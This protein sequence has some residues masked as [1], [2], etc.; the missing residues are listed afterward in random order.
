M[1]MLYSRV[2]SCG[3]FYIRS[4]ILK[5]TSACLLVFILGWVC[6]PPFSQTAAEA[7]PNKGER[8]AS[9][10]KPGAKGCCARCPYGTHQA[11][12]GKGQSQVHRR[13]AIGLHQAPWHS[14]TDDPTLPTV[15]VNPPTGVTCGGLAQPKGTGWSWAR[16]EAGS[17][18]RVVLRPVSAGGGRW[19]SRAR[20]PR[21]GLAAETGAQERSGQLCQRPPTCCSPKPAPAAPPPRPAPHPAPPPGRLLPAPPL[22]PPLSLSRPHPLRALL[23]PRGGSS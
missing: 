1:K 7:I 12:R 16:R 20:E 22:V 8:M 10:G 17:S 5:G 18:G 13:G 9:W 6:E 11:G 19:S 15:K 23:R 21:V 14:L 3:T 2:P 4:A